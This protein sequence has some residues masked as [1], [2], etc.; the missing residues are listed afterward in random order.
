MS[1]GFRHYGQFKITAQLGGIA[2]QGCR[3]R[4]LLAADRVE[5]QLVEMSHPGI[6]EI[7]KDTMTQNRGWRRSTRRRHCPWRRPG[8][9]DADD[10]ISRVDAVGHGG[11]VCGCHIVFFGMTISSR[12]LS[13][14]YRSSSKTQLNEPLSTGGRCNWQHQKYHRQDGQQYVGRDRRST[15][16][17]GHGRS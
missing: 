1:V 2:P 13:R 9:V 7:I 3:Q 6:G 12:A 5:Q 14:R 11:L 15:S 8:S 4:T 16:R 17:S 10:N